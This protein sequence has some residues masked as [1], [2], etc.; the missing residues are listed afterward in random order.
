MTAPTAP[1][2]PATYTIALEEHFALPEILER[3]SHVS[4]PQSDAAAAATRPM[5]LD[6]GDQRLAAMDAA[7]VDLQVL[8][9]TA[10]GL[11]HV[12]GGD[13]PA[14]A[15][16]ANDAVL[17]A[18]ARHPTRFAGFATLAVGDPAAAA[19][20]LQRTAG[21]G[22][23][24]ALV[25][26][27][28]QGRFLDH[29]SFDDLLGVAEQLDVPLY[30]HPGVPPPEVVRAYYAG[31]SDDVTRALST[32][33]WGWHAETA[34]HVLRLVLAGVFDR[35]PRLQVVIGHMGETLPVMLDR[36]SSLL[37]PMSGLQRPVRDYLTSHVHLTIAGVYS[38]PAF[39]AALQTWGS[40]RL[41]YST[42]FPY[43][44][45]AAAAKFLADVQ[46]SPADRRRFAAGN[47]AALLK[48][49]LLA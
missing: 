33:A 47:A 6:L 38:Q 12:P 8:S 42:D 23:R 40:D 35:H 39:L 25:N 14:L 45:G 26:G 28:V 41:M 31:F 17:D 21:L 10:P 1:T 30:V 22:L 48:L 32:V 18:V 4:G 19:E 34:V 24:G 36:A 2:A 20:E 13:A 15:R 5:L 27:M 3:T 7:G 49:E 16:A 37:S 43:V 29:P 46:L 11:E 9:H 44:P